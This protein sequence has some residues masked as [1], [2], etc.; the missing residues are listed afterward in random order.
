M[1]QLTLLAPQTAEFGPFGL[2]TLVFDATPYEWFILAADAL[3]EGETVSIVVQLGPS[4]DDIP[5][6]LY[7][8]TDDAGAVI[9]LSSSIPSRRLRG[10][11]QYQ[12]HKAA[13]AAPCGV[14]VQLGPRKSP[15]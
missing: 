7:D 1:Q 6:N 9:N 2:T 15:R 8:A 5:S 12:F 13:T 10:G 4:R 11:I 14:Y 3:G